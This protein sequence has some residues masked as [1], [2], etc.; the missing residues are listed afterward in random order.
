MRWL[1]RWQYIE[2]AGAD[3]LASIYSDIS[4]SQEVW[5]GLPL[6]AR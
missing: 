5:A 6:E 1:P 2:M 4:I 3:W